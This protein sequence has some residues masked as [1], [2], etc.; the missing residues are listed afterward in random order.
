MEANPIYGN[1][2][3]CIEQLYSSGSQKQAVNRYEAFFYSNLLTEFFSTRFHP[4]ELHSSKDEM[5]WV[6][7]SNRGTARGWQSHLWFAV[8]KTL[9]L[10]VRI[11]IKLNFWK[12]FIE[13]PILGF[14]GIT[15]LELGKRSRQN[16]RL[17]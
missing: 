13:P 16:R 1:L 14:I 7:V 6:S 10:P 15:I 8:V 9:M 11:R 17:K 2:E 3:Y 12:L 5:P 4:L